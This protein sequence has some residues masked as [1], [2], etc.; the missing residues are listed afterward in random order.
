VVAALDKD[1]PV[2][3]TR[4]MDEW[5]GRSVTR[6]RQRTGLTGIFAGAALL[7]AALGGFGT[8][9]FS[10]VSRTREIGIRMARG[11]GRGPI[12]S[13]VL[14]Q[15]LRP[16]V[17]GAAIGLAAAAAGAR[18]L[19]GLLYRVPA[20]DPLVFAIV[21]AALLAV[22]AL[23]AYLPARRAAAVDPMVA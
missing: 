5:V 14:G 16:V 21:P 18:L 11:A 2:Y 4:T 3:D 19:S 15:G 9:A 23:A 6:P 12:P 7:L 20:T 13:G 22:A 1:L 10:V 17:A 8:G